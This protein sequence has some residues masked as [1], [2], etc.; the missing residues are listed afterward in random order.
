MF[1]YM[2]MQRKKCDA[3][4]SPAINI[5]LIIKE[6][7]Q[8]QNLSVAWLSRKINCDRRNI[9]DIFNRHTIDTG[10]L[11]RLSEAL[12]VNFFTYYSASLAAS[13]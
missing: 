5:G 9:Y 11:F 12:G 2:N 6:E 10:L 4:A 1:D 7:L 8:R 3:T 13:N